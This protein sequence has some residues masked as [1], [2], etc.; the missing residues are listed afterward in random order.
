MSAKKWLIK[1]QL[2]KKVGLIGAF[3]CGIIA[4]MLVTI[5]LLLDILTDLGQ[6]GD[7]NVVCGWN[8]TDNVKYSVGC[9]AGFDASC[10][11]KT[12]GELWLILEI[13]SIALAICACILI[14]VKKQFVRYIFI[15]CGLICI[16][17]P[18]AW[19]ANNPICYNND[20][21]NRTLGASPIMAIIAGFIY[22]IA[23]LLSSVKR[24]KGSYTVLK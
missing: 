14:G 10:K 24:Q 8:Q 9:D 4:V 13:I 7:S 5:A 15:L 21:S 18:I 2:K 3:I 11:T 1:R 20:L 23:G 16:C 6:V 17:G 19:V 12:A 22:I